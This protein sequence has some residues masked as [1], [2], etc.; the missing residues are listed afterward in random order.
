M[1]KSQLSSKVLVQALHTLVQTEDTTG[2]SQEAPKATEAVPVES[3]HL[4][5]TESIAFLIH[6]SD[7]CGFAWMRR[8]N[9]DNIDIIRNYLDFLCLLRA[10]PGY[11]E[12]HAMILPE[13]LTPAALG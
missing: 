5:M 11:S 13:A 7:F 10:N 12:A 3:A 9:K 2:A 1:Q 4:G 8:V 6:G